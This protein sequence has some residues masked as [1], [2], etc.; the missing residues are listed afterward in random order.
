MHISLLK[1]LENWAVQIS[2]LKNHLDDSF[3]AEHLYKQIARS[4]T[5]VVLNYAE[6]KAAE[7]KNDFIHKLSIALKEL[8]ES[9][10]NLKLLRES[11]CCKNKK[12]INSRLRECNSFIM[13]IVK[14][15]KTLKAN[16]T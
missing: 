14:S 16:S 9:K 8:D 13:H 3:L 6:S 10:A 7:S 11:D 4:S 5:S 1:K 2:E 15:L 12:L